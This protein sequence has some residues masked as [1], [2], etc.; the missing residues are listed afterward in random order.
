MGEAG[1]LLIVVAG[2][3]LAAGLVMILLAKT[4]LGRL[5]GDLDIRSQ[6]FRFVFPLT[7]CV[8]LSLLLTA[9]LW[10]IQRFRH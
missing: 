2:V 10:I 9:I 3:C 5:P 1:K 4:P 8:L 7:T 6:G